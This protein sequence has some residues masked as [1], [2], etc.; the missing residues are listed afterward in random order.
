MS[1][2]L[3]LWGRARSVT[4]RALLNATLGAQWQDDEDDERG[5][6]W[7]WRPSASGDVRSAGTTMPIGGSSLSEPRQP[8]YEFLFDQ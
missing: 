6:Y 3:K 5:W 4:Y 2:G 7:A 1:L 8:A